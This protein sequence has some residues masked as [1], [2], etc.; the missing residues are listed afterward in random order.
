MSGYFK[1][2]KK[3][4]YSLSESANNYQI[5]TNIFQR[6]NF[7]RAI[8]D[9]T[10]NYYEYQAKDGDTPEIIADKLYGDASRHWIILLFNQ[11]INPYYIF[12]L[13]PEGLNEYITKKYQQTL[14]EAQT[15]VHHY[16][17]EITRVR[18]VTYY[19]DGISD[20]N[21]ISDE[22]VETQIISEYEADY[23]TGKLT[24]RSLPAIDQSLTF[25]PETVTVQETPKIILTE[26]KKIT[27]V[28]NYT[29][30]LLENEK[31]RNIKLLDKRYVPQLELEFKTMMQ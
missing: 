17:L 21:T 2:F 31:R 10:V 19:N 25:T 13:S 18:S 26:T 16:E 24:K 1:N 3:T 14:E 23:T 22:N 15:T 30:E 11:I 12:P 5:V 4:R 9:K 8:I 29:Y 7:L 27:S 6:S 20:W 28:S